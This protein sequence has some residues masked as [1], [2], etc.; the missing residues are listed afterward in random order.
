MGR[1]KNEVIQLEEDIGAAIDK[2]EK[3]LKVDLAHD[4]TMLFEIA[5]NKVWLDFICNHVNDFG[6]SIFSDKDEV[7]RFI[8]N[9]ATE[10]GKEDYGV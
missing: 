1:V 8:I 3:I 4:D 7:R 10:M 6:N 9:K 5:D 2:M